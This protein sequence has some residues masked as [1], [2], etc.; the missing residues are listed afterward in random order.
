MGEGCGNDAALMEYV[1]SANIACGF[2]AGDLDTMRRTVDLALESRVAVGAHPGYADR[3]RFG[4]MRIS[5]P[6]KEIYNIV[7]EQI[8]ALKDVCSRA[9]GTLHHVKPHGALYNQAATDRD[10][11]R[12]LVD[13]V[14]DVD[15]GLILFGL[16]G[17]VMIEEA[18]KSGMRTASEVF[19]DRTYGPDGMLTPRTQPDALVTDTDKAI[20]QV[21]GMIN[22]GQVTTTDGNAVPMRADTVC[23]HGD[24]R[25]A[26]QFAEAIYSE[27]IDA[28]IEIR[29]L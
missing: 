21:M 10:M 17:S 9:G 15:P 19:A 11:A 8:R 27:L 22:D 4:R 24:G 1:S 25:N 12:T 23:I 6:N 3:E 14:R 20:S 2:H 28:G 18:E 7:T 13:A 16:S 26:L 29:S 5:L